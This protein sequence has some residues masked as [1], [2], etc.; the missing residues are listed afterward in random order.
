MPLLGGPVGT[1]DVPALGERRED[2][3]SATVLP[4]DGGPAEQAVRTQTVQVLPPEAN[5]SGD[6]PGRGASLLR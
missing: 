3:E 6:Y 5:T 1:C 2:E 4:F